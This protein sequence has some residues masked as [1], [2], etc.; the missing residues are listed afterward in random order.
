V[1]N[2]SIYSLNSCVKSI[3]KEEEEEEEEEELENK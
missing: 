1:N 3:Y 2:N